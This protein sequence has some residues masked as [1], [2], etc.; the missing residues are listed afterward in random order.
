MELREFEYAPL[1]RLF[2]AVE[3][4]TGSLDTEDLKESLLLR[5]LNPDDTIA[6]VERKVRA[7]SKT[8]CPS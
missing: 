4:E 8:H 5:G 2:R 1:E 6:F 3:N 7:F